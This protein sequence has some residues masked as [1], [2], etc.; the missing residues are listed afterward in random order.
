MMKSAKSSGERNSA[1]Q[2]LGKIPAN[3]RITSNPEPASRYLKLFKTIS[4]CRCKKLAT[5]SQP[6]DIW[7]Q[8]TISKKW[9]LWMND[10]WRDKKIRRQREKSA[11]LSNILKNQ[12]WPWKILPHCSCNAVVCKSDYFFH[13]T[14]SH[15]WPFVFIPLIYGR[16][17]FIHAQKHLLSMF[18]HDW[19]S[20]AP[21]TLL[22]LSTILWCCCTTQFL[23]ILF[24]P[25][26]PTYFLL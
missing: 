4:K 14:F 22:W 21:S 2:S 24:E 1:P 15:W 5:S 16:H 8:S 6:V 10:N 25:F 3:S 23:K 17:I 12:P 19:P 11:V 7:N 13:H 9:Q 18:L 26:V 20:P